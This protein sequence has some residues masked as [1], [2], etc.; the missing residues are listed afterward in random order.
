MEKK[1]YKNKVSIIIPCYNQE[2]KIGRCL[3]SVLN[4]KLKEK[5]IIIVNDGSTDKTLEILKKYENKNIIIINQKNK[6]QAV[7]RNTGLKQST[8]EYIS[9]IDSDDFVEKNYTYKLYKK[10]IDN[11]SDYVYCDYYEYSNNKNKYISSTYNDDTDK[12]KIIEN[13]APWG[14]LISHELINKIDFKFPNLKMCEDIAVIPML[15]V[16]SVKACHMKEGLYYYNLDSSS[17]TRIKVYDDKLLEIMKIPDILYNYF[18]DNNLLE[19]YKDELKYTFVQNILKYGVL[20][21][22]KHKESLKYI[23]ILRK[24]IKNKFNNLLSCKYY[25]YDTL[26]SKLLIIISLYFPPKVLYVLNKIKNRKK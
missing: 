13:F 21:L 8:G 5:E 20:N 24:S 4:D 2:E 26:Y 10:A 18:K 22:A 12:V 11:N 25:K 9:F 17:L 1:K 16:N 3:D 15:A 6:G 23:K 7:A 14:K 19:E